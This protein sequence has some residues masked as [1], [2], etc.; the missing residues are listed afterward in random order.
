MAD[1]FDT[2]LHAVNDA[3]EQYLT[4][5]YDPHRVLDAM[6]YSASAGGKRIRPMLTL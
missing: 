2:Y 1:L 5:P 6:H 3:L 4:A